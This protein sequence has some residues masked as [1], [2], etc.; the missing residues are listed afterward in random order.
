MINAPQCQAGLGT[1]LRALLDKL[2][3]ELM[4]LYR[5]AGSEFRPKYYPIAR[6]LRAEREVSLAQLARR[7]G[8]THSA[9]SQTAAEMARGELVRMRPGKDA[10]ERLVSLSAR[11]KRT[12]DRLEAL[13]L[14][15]DAAAAELDAELSAALSSV[16]AEALDALARRPFGGRVRE[17]LARQERGEAQR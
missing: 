15:V 1:Q 3:G 2:D 8:V 14:A 5:E 17:H 12:C 9:V 6:V 11:G 10:R 4:R 16:V 13:W 7:C